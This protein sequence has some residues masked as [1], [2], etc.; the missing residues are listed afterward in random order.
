MA[1]SVYVSRENAEL[2][3]A[4]RNISRAGAALADIGIMHD[5]AEGKAA[6]LLFLTKAMAL[7]LATD[8]NGNAQA[9]V[10]RALQATQG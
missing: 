9:L 1:D 4:M 2:H 3:H 5:S 8:E 6:A 7:I 10:G